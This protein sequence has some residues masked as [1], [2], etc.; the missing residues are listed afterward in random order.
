MLSFKK[1]DGLTFTNE[2]FLKELFPL[3]EISGLTRTPF[4]KKNS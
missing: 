1:I 4:K 2:K 3:L